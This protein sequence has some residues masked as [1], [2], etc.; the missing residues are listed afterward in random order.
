MIAQGSHG[1]R[2]SLSAGHDE[3]FSNLL[4]LIKLWRAWQCLLACLRTKALSPGRRASCLVPHASCVYI[5]CTEYGIYANTYIR[6]PPGVLQGLNRW[7]H[8]PHKLLQLLLHLNA[9]WKRKTVIEN[10]QRLGPATR[11]TIAS[12]VAS[13]RLTLI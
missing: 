1:S 9:R 2:R 6:P 3:L 11:D 7:C 13:K 4:A 8:L 5:A 12:R 10:R